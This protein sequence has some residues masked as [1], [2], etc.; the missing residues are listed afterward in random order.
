MLLEVARGEFVENKDYL[1]LLDQKF[2][3]GILM[4]GS[5][6]RHR[7]LSDFTDGTRPLLLVNN[8]SKEWNLNYVVSNYHHGAWQAARHLIQLGHRRIGFISGGLSE[9]QTSRDV[10]EAFCTVLR[11]NGIEPAA[12]RVVDGWLT[13][14]GG[15]QAAEKLLTQDPQLTAIFALDDKMALG[16]MKKLSEFGVRVPHDVAV[17][18]FDDIPA[19]SYSIPG[20]TTVHQPLYE[21]GK[22][23]CERLI[24][25]VHGK[26]DRV[27]EVMPVHLVVRESCGARM[28]EQATAG[29][30]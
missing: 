8:Y 1:Q 15:M 28:K 23:S 5:S 13:E 24:E 11:E 4:V 25:L 10:F 26:V 2:V 3:D 6:S 29:R 9:I 21:I 27:Q 22:L 7:F 16:A 20:L 12:E 30:V 19:G 14:E 17:I 18:G